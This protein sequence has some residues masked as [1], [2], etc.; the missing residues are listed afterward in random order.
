[1]IQEYIQN[2]FSRKL[3][4]KPNLVIYDQERRYAE[5]VQLLAS[6]QVKV[7]D[8]GSSAISAREEAVHYW[9]Q[10]LPQKPAQKV[11]LYLPFERPEN[12]QEK[13]FDPFFIFGL[14]GTI[15][16][17]G[18]SDEYKA[19][20]QACYPN[21]REKIDQLFSQGEIPDFATVDAVKGGN[22]Y[23]K[24]QSATNEKSEKEVILALLFPND[25]QSKKLK[26]NKGWIKEY[27]LIS[28]STIGLK[29]EGK[30]LDSIQEE[31]WR[32]L[33]FS[34]FVIDLPIELPE[35]LAK[36]PRADK[37]FEK[38]VLDICDRIR[39][40]KYIEDIYITK[41]NEISSALSLEEHFRNAKDLGAI[42]TFAFEDNTYFNNFIDHLLNREFSKAEHL[43]RPNR[44]NEIWREDQNRSAYWLVGKYAYELLSDISRI[45]GKWK[46]AFRNLDTAFQ[47]YADELWKLDQAHRYF[48][49]SVKEVLSLSDSL[50]EL[51]KQVRNSYFVFWQDLQK[52]YQQLIAD[53]GWQFDNTLRNDELFDQRIAPLLKNSEKVAYFMVDALRFELGKELQHQLEQYFEVKLDPGA[54]FVPT[55]TRYAMAALLP[56]AKKAMELRI[57]GK[58]LEPFLKDRHIKGPPERLEYIKTDCNY[59]D[60]ADLITL[61]D[62]LSSDIPDKDLLIVT[63]TEIDAAGESLVQNVQTL[64]QESLRKIIRAVR[65]LEEAGYHKVVMV[66]DHGF[67]LTEG[68]KSGDAV[69][70][71]AGDWV[72]QKSRFVAGK[73]NTDSHLIALKPEDIGLKAEVAH[74]QFLHNYAVFKRGLSYFHEGLSMQENIVPCLEVKLS[75]AVGK[76]KVEIQLSYKGKDHGFITML[77]P[78]IELSSFSEGSLFGEP[79]IVKLEALGT[80]GE[81]VGTTAPGPKVNPTNGLIE[82]EPGQSF[83]TTIAMEEDYE[84]AFE[85]IASDPVTGLVYSTIKLKTAYL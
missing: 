21:Q 27:H 55:V 20:C 23:P 61:D 43:L 3:E 81:V 79:V 47:Y 80:N 35:A 10:V 70:K 33:L 50:S 16:P 15:F 82:L 64:I 29:P 71:P 19:L 18:P 13:I 65:Q 17:S 60:R 45:G 66:A 5:L 42:V 26:K 75:Q 14:G 2:H 36:V 67:V 4:D 62:L 1:M 58:S 25:E 76:P 6:D 48:E 11:V 41:A 28:T 63:T 7:I 46:S 72:V 37:T 51:I 34:E 83:K 74:F 32:Y 30:T 78:S 49:Q 85:V 38:V 73:G 12:E 44:S 9:T 40:R 84:G 22:N 31:L 54:A 56:E 68:Y 39:S 59:G 8:V 77:R 57:K 53:S 24:L 52:S 69:S